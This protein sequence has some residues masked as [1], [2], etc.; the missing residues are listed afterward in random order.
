MLNE[1][2][3]GSSFTRQPDIADSSSAFVLHWPAT[4]SDQH[5]GQSGVQLR[6]HSVQYSGLSSGVSSSQHRVDSRQRPS[7][8]HSSGQLCRHSARRDGVALSALLSST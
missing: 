7:V 2:W 4:V 5:S 8:R 3:A 6:C 1:P